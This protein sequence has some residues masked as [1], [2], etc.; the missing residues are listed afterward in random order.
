MP[1][2]LYSGNMSLTTDIKLTTNIK[3]DHMTLTQKVGTCFP[4]QQ[5][6]ISTDTPLH[7]KIWSQA[8][9]MTY[10]CVSL[11]AFLVQR[12][13]DWGLTWVGLQE[14]ENSKTISLPSKTLLDTGLADAAWKRTSFGLFLIYIIFRN[15]I[16]LFNSGSTSSLVWVLL[17]FTKKPSSNERPPDTIKS[18]L[19]QTWNLSWPSLFKISL[20][21][22]RIIQV[23]IR[24]A[25][26]LN[27]PRCSM[28]NWGRR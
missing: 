16:C 17:Q 15:H 24:K 28:T 4:L 11:H 8:Y 18:V 25:A 1:L 13:K 2:N 6:V 27:Q 23:F 7:Q 5:S 3:S 26:N 21:D 22:C 14:R 19:W 10:C 12:C 9:N 20:T